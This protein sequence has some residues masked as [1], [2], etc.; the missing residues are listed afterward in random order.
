MDLGDVDIIELT[1]SIDR[2]RCGDASAL[3]GDGAAG[4]VARRRVSDPVAADGPAG[5]QQVADSLGSIDRYGI[6]M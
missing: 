3:A 6:C 5:D 2:T 4:H 1:A